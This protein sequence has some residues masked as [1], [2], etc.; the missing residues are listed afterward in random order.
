MHQ[1]DISGAAL[2]VM[3]YQYLS[4]KISK[5]FNIAGWAMALILLDWVMKNTSSFGS[6]DM[7]RSSLSDIAVVHYHGHVEGRMGFESIPAGLAQRTQAQ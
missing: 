7:F 6:V 4:P 3:A 1:N 5:A 2:A